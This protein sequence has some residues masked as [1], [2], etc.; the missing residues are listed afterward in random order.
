MTLNQLESLTED[1][2]GLALYVVNVI[3]PPSIPKMEFQPRHLTWFKHDA[4]VKKL[5]DSFS[6]LKPEGHAT[7]TSLME[8]L[9]VKIEIKA[10]PPPQHGTK[11]ECGNEHEVDHSEFG[12]PLGYNR[13]CNKCGRMWNIEITSTETSTEKTASLSEPVVPK[14]ETPETGSTA[15]SSSV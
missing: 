5:L 10:V 12:L 11:C 9:G 14:V 7:Y 8:K 6:K 15:I 1:E 13:R 3:A 2:M 4:L